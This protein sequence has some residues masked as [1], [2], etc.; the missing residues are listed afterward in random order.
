MT[1]KITIF[2]FISLIFLQACTP[3]EE[4]A[5]DESIDFTD[6]VDKVDL[7]NNFS[8]E[9]DPEEIETVET[10]SSYLAA[11]LEF[12]EKTLIDSLF[13]GELIAEENY[14]EGPGFQAKNGELIEY[15]TIYD[16][17]KS[18]GEET[19]VFGGFTYSNNQH[20]MNKISTVISN[21]PGHPD[22]VEQL[23]KSKYKRD[24]ASESK[25]P[26]MDYDEALIEITD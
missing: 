3:N 2:L 16:G 25:L 7:P 22:K 4:E 8:L 5:I 21:A 6:W 13:S 9:I 20:F 12:E 18:F 15:L 19:G 14:A 10:A 23:H 17:G 24:F 1:K 11:P 26:F